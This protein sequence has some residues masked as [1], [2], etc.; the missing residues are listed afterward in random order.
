[1]AP[2]GREVVE[3]YGRAVA[4]ADMDA[5]VAVLHDDVI[6]EYPQSGERVV[7]KANMRAL[8]E[9]YPGAEQAPLHGTVTKVVGAEDEWVV[10]PSY[11]MTHISGSGDDY[12][13]AGMID[14]PNG[15]TW[16]I[17]MLVRLRDG[18]IWRITSYFAS[19]FEAPEWRAAWVEVPRRD[20]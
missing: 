11:T 19:P 16:H 9:H 3:R 12:A 20:N 1:M 17:V 5:M 4:A 7:G 2:S 14:Y 10:G 18:L 6:D 13:L 15:E 8:V